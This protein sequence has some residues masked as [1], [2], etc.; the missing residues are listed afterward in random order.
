M[1][2]PNAVTPL[3]PAIC[4]R[5][6]VPLSPKHDVNEVPNAEDVQGDTYLRFPKVRLYRLRLCIMYRSE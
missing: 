1:A 3:P 4:R 6:I 5:S 2:P